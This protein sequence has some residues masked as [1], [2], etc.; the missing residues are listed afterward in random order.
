MYDHSGKQKKPKGAAGKMSN[1]C[2]I[3]SVK[4]FI[5]KIT[6]HKIMDNLQI[7]NSLCST[8]KMVLR[9]AA[10]LALI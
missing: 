5:E 3:S 10:L 8:P 7:N 4:Y 6:V 2:P 1:Y 9:S